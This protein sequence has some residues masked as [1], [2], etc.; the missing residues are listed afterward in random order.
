MCASVSDCKTKLSVCITEHE[1]MKTYRWWRY[2]STIL[3][4]GIRCGE[5]S[6]SPS[7]VPLRQQPPVFIGY[8]AGWAPEPLQRCL[9]PLL[10][11]ELLFPC[12]Q[13]RHYIDRATLHSDRVPESDCRRFQDQAATGSVP[14]QGTEKT[15]VC[16]KAARGGEWNVVG[17]ELQCP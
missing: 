17:W 16:K 2:S 3:D 14:Q 13:A 10:G 7:A 8:E 4:L 1:A 5:R 15:H 11:T 6:A 9:L 12:H